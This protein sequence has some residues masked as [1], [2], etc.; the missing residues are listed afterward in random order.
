[1]SWSNSP[2]TMLLT[3]L[4]YDI[5]KL[6]ELVVGKFELQYDE[7]EETI[8]PEELAHVA[9]VLY[10]NTT[11]SAHKF[12]DQMLE[13]ACLSEEASY[14]N[15]TFMK[16]LGER[17]ELQQF[18]ADL[19]AKVV[20]MHTKLVEGSWQERKKF[21]REIKVKDE[22]TEAYMVELNELS[23]DQTELFG[24]IAC[25]WATVRGLRNRLREAGVDYA[26]VPG[27]S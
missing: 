14:N 22:I 3:F 1:M 2:P 19:L 5:P 6:R 11:P 9:A 27:P 18:S 13:A 4:D 16:L 10:A 17:P 21:R 20:R 26:D 8:T 12:R 7:F 25:L 23:S 24:K 15:R